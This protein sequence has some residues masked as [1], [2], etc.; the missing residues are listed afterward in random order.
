LINDILDLAVT[1]AGALMLDRGPIDIDPMVRGVV[2]MVD[3]QARAR[4]LV[5]SHHID[6]STGALEGDERRLK[7]VLYNLL[8]NAIQYTPEGGTVSLVTSGDPDFVLM[9]V[10]DTGVGIADAE[11]DDVFERFRRGSNVGNTK[12]SGLGLALVK[13]IVDMHDGWVELQSQVGQGTTVSIH[14]PR[15]QH[16]DVVDAA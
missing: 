9:Q 15:R 3:E 14:L 5:L 10:I 7:Q 11:Q 1:D 6:T 2:T 8:H 13:H 12:G 4:G 16:D